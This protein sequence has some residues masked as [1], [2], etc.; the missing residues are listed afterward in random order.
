MPLTKPIFTDHDKRFLAQ[1]L[2]GEMPHPATVFEARVYLERAAATMDVNDHDQ[3]LH[4]AT[5][6]EWAD[7][8]DPP[9]VPASRASH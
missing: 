7:E 6:I 4:R 8:I 1:F 5:L 2:G 9:S 3:R